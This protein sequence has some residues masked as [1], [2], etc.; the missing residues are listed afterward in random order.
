MLRKFAAIRILLI[1][2]QDR[3][4][5]GG[6]YVSHQLVDTEQ[7]VWVIG[8][9]KQGVMTRNPKWAFASRDAAEV[10]VK[11]NSGRLANFDETMTAAFGDLYQDSN[12]IREKRKM[13]KK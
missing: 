3:V 4:D 9:A 8:G 10:F 7:A 11:E 6:N 2:A 5:G 13:R 1:T 12:M